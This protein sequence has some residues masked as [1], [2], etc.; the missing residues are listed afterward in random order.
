MTELST[1]LVRAELDAS[2]L[3]RLEEQLRREP[4]NRK[5]RIL[6]ATARKRLTLHQA[7]LDD[8]L[9]GAQT[10]IIDYRIVNRDDA[11]PVLS[12]SDSLS[13]FQ[14]SITAVYDALEN[15]PKSRARYS[16]EVAEASKVNFG[17]SYPG[18]HGF[19]LTAKS[20]TSLFGGRLDETA[21]TIF[22]YIEISGT[23]DAIE[24]SRK[25][26]LAA[27]SELYAW[28]KTNATWRN[29][30][31]LN[32][33]TSQSTQ[34][35]R[36]IESERFLF[37]EQIFSA[38]EDREEATFSIIGV[39]VGL[40]VET[41]RFHIAVPNGESIKGNF[42]ERYNALPATVPGN[43]RAVVT[44]IT[45]RIPASGKEVVAFELEQLT[46]TSEPN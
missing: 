20:E 5:L 45:R 12:V 6:V 31:D 22:E 43:C 32:W 34:K 17:Y 7:H 37:L 40:D 30:I 29:A 8:A 10:D 26:G 39:L 25:L 33:K 15:G 24:A 44:K 23:N 16:A 2:R 42:S 14:R 3:A 11:Y 9:S 1:K 27:V 28:V 18:S 38:A 41:Q 46:D 4:N 36:F 19:V 21:K 35:G 13:H